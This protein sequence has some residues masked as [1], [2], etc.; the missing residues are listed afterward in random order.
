VR[1]KNRDRRDQIGEPVSLTNREAFALRPIR[2][3]IIAAWALGASAIVPERVASASEARIDDVVSSDVA[4]AANAF[5]QAQRAELRREHAQAAELYELAN[6]L[7]PSP[8]ALRSAVRNR[9]LAGQHTRAATHAYALLRR[10]DDEQSQ[11]LA[12]RILDEL[13]PGLTKVHVSCD[14]PCAV[15]ADGRAVAHAPDTDHVFFVDPGAHAL[16]VVFEGS[17]PLQ[18]SVYGEPG[19]KLPLVV[20]RPAT[21]RT[22]A[23]TRRAD[24]STQPASEPDR[25]R[26]STDPT[27]VAMDLGRSARRLSPAWFGVGA[28]MTVGLGATALWSGIDVLR[29]NDDYETMPTEA[30]YDAGRRAEL[31]TNVLIGVTSGIALT[32]VVL[33]IL[34]DWSKHSKPSVAATRP[35]VRPTFAGSA[36]GLEGRF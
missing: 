35:R 33:A 12:N 36:V 24:A 9:M 25:P 18:R 6:E 31:R 7:V 10:H 21:P 3:S 14:E 2:P 29:R 32:T 4:A 15:S 1:K 19:E 30:G 23:S 5:E 16:T 20:T 27:P 17:D 8:E 26:T 11:A 22:N 13:R 34:T 28:A